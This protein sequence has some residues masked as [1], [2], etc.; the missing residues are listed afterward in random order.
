MRKK[1]NLLNNMDGFSIFGIV[2]ALVVVGIMTAMTL[3]SF[4]AR[5]QYKQAQYVAGVFKIIANS[6]NAYMAKNGLFGN[7]VTL[8]QNGYLSPQFLQSI[9][10]ADNPGGPYPQPN[11]IT[12]PFAHQTVHLCIADNGGC[13]NNLSQNGYFIGLYQV[14]VNYATYIKHE[15]PGSGIG[16]QRNGIDYVA[17][18][19]PVAS[20]PPVKKAEYATTAGSVGSANA[21]NPPSGVSVLYGWIQNDSP[22]YVELYFP[23][24]GC[25]GG[26]RIF[27]PGFR[28]YGIENRST[29]TRGRC[30]YGKD[31]YINS[32]TSSP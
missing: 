4:K 28:G 7:L 2:I 16:S 22:N 23:N 25:H 13:P 11:W 12:L 21:I 17:Y 30:T 8:S 6:E 29:G 27:P 32:F 5:M 18:S 26:I 31:I 19:A 1:N 3:P 14:P 20:A 15:I 24:E 10:P 9:Q